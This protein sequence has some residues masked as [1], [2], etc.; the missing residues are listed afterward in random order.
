MTQSKVSKN[1][2]TLVIGAILLALSFT[3]SIFLF[4]ILLDRILLFQFRD[5]FLNVSMRILLTLVLFQIF[6]G[7]LKKTVIKPVIWI[8]GLIYCLLL[9]YVVM[10]KVPGRTGV[11]LNPLALIHDLMTIP[12]Y[13]ISNFLFF[14]PAGFFLGYVFRKMI[15]KILFL[16]GFIVSVILELIQ[17]IFQIGIFDVTDII[18]NG[19]GFAVG[20]WLFVLVCRYP[21]VRVLLVEKFKIKGE[22]EDGEI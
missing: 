21:K 18:L 6:W 3:L 12:F 16:A 4:R 22:C 20:V 8:T 2:I 10:V 1:M 7:I 11:N 5:A 9:L 17:L 14:A 15:P 13:P 19:S